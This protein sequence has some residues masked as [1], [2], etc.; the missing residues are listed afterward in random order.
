GEVRLGVGVELAAVNGPSSV[1]VA[2]DPVA[3]DRLVAEY[4]AE[5]VRVRR[6]PVDYASHTS[7]VEL[8][9][10]EL[11]E[12]L[13]GL[14]P[15]SAT[16]P[17][18]S[19]VDG[20]WVEGAE[21]D[22]GYWFRNLRQTVRFADATTALAAEGFRAFVEVSAHPV[23]AH[24]IQE[25]L[26]E[27][28]E[29]PSV[30]TGTLRRDD[31]GP[32]RLLLS[33]A[34]LY[35]RGI[36]VDW[37]TS[38]GEPVPRRVELPTYAFQRQRYWLE[39]SPGASDLAAVG[40]EEAG[41]PLL[42]A[43]ITLADTDRS[44]FS[45]RLTQREHPWLDD[46]RVGGPMLL[47]GTALLDMLCHIGERLRVP[48]VDELTISA[49]IVVPD[50]GGVDLQITVEHEAG[51]GTRVV[52]VY[53]RSGADEGWS[54]NATGLLTASSEPSPA[55]A[56]LTSWPPAGARPVD[57]D[58]FYDRLTVDYGPAFRAVEAAWVRDGRV[59]AALRLPESGAGTSDEIDGYG[60]HPALLDAALHPLSVSD[61]FADPD[62]PRLAFSWAGVRL[63]ATGARSLR[64]VLAPAGP[65][66]VSISAADDTG[67]PVL[68]VDALTVRPVDPARL[69]TSAPQ[70]GGSLFEVVWVPGPAAASET[71]QWAFH[72]GLGGSEPSV[73][74]VVVLRTPD[75]SPDRTVPE[76]V[77]AV[78]LN[79]L[80][81][82]QEWLADP[83]TQAS[84]L[85]V[86][87]RR[88]DLV[89]EPVRGLVRT[90]QSEHPGRFGLLEVERFD[91]ESVS[92]GLGGGLLD[93]PQVAVRGEQALV[94]RLTR[95]Q[96]A[97]LPERPRLAGGTVLVTG[98]TGGLGRLVTDHL[99]R[100]HE[101]A[102]LV[103][104]SRSG[105]PDE[106]L[107]ELSASGVRVSAVA[108]DVGDREALARIVAAVSDRLTAVV[109][110]AGVVDDGVIGELDAERWHTALRPKVDAA[111]HLHE[112]TE[113]L[114][115]TAFVLYSSASSTFGGSGQ[116]NYA[117]GNAFLDAL[118]VHRRAKGLAAVSLAWG[119]WAESAGMGGRLSDTDLAR[120]ARAG[121]RPLS[122]EQGLA[123]FDA[124]LESDS[125]ALVPI[126]LDLAAV[127]DSAEIPVLLSDLV[128]APTRRVIRR[129][130]AAGSDSASTLKRRLIALGADEQL[131]VLLDLVRS[132]AAAVLG[133]ATADAIEAQRAFKELGVDSLTA[134]ELR[135]RLT[136]ATGLRL[137]VTL[138]FNYPTAS[139]LAG[140]LR[141]EL[142]GEEALGQQQP[143]D[144]AVA[145]SS[146]H[147]P[148][149][150]A[151][152][153]IAIVAIGC[154][155]PGGLSSAEDLW[156]LV[157]AGGD[158]I[159]GL[160]SDRG[161]DLDGLYDPDP[162]SPGK[163]YVR[164]GGFLQDVGGF[165]AG[166]F[167]INPRE[168]LAMDPQQRLL[169]E[170][171]WE[172]LERAGI[173]PASLKG[174]PTGVFVGTHGQDYG[175]GETAG[176]ADEGYLV[177]GNAGSVLSGR[178]SYTLGL[179]G[180]ALTVDTACSSSLVA[181]H[182][183]VQALRNGECTLALAGGVS[184]MSTLEGVVGFSRQRGLATDGRSKAF[185][186]SA[187][188]FGMSEG[189]GI[190]LV[191]R[192]SDA[193]RLGHEVLAVVRG[194]AVNQ[195]GASNGLTAPN[196][197][198]QERVI[199]QALAGARLS[200]S[201]VDAVEA[202]GTG[203][204][205]GDP[206]EA[207]ALL[208][209][210]GKGRPAESPLWM[211]SVKSNIGHAQAAAGVAGVI[212]MVQAIRH[213]VLPRTLHV[214]E[215]SSKVDWSSGAVELLT[216]S[217]SWPEVDR[218]RRAGVSAF[219][220]SGTNAHVIVEQAP[221]V[222]EVAVVPEVSDPEPAVVPWVISGA[223]A[224]G[225]R[226]QAERLESFA[227]EHQD[228]P[229]PAIGHALTTTRGA[230]AHRA[231]VLAGDRGGALAGVSVVAG[232]GVGSG[233]VSGV[234]DVS[235][236]SV[237]VFPGQGSQWVGMGRDLLDSSPVFAGA[238]VEV[239]GVLGAVSG[240][241]VL[242]VVRGVEGAASLD[243]VDVV[244]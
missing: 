173:D 48:V 217:R 213:G 19:S 130:T 129:D 73:P 78:G 18:Y 57:M 138:V 16:I 167:G 185:A 111:W 62:S 114:D 82:L 41:H 236:R 17:M 1:V 134:V 60:I 170:V 67:A 151:D 71:P 164:G 95:A 116:G 195:D 165:D 168:A 40:L 146:S 171:S 72:T 216:E 56:D 198:S 105:V 229:D 135:N 99:V 64:V 182:L 65:D 90:A 26:D 224:K 221:V 203:T 128:P 242:D 219:G 13:A 36:P 35:V 160:P 163:T 77:H 197:P 107:A 29:A 177:T 124:A 33:V 21:L 110:V 4:E 184:V 22:G 101:V 187:D 89:Q 208:A 8:I 117:A 235:G 80:G 161:W 206:I 55:Q 233:V 191:E 225:L 5:G 84:R 180:P 70:L 15:R 34:E 148:G 2:G 231:V 68:D 59:Y 159:T 52:R 162:D 241:S 243:R 58:G 209:T 136:A 44:V 156:Q 51:P 121:T 181:L 143:H 102:E 37:S 109:H 92:A 202:H 6:V 232:G 47:P 215:P 218:P 133:H 91:E 20:R 240:W 172:V 96:S 118:A 10:A 45:G 214:D 11:A 93:E 104:V 179:E 14:K 194:S 226:G 196:G 94:A 212:K 220:V 193:R 157:E 63:H 27:K 238:L 131:D 166:F 152:E 199:R 211:G 125:P 38:F 144:P 174:T 3:L 192:L 53:T 120:M 183:A 88:D 132:S 25:T 244:Q 106:R 155:F 137:P 176:Q 103:L 178:V 46:H 98:A 115:L 139:E 126:R 122:A 30:V 145:S 188:G 119:L 189:V 24:S 31:G 200:A 83:R 237:F 76:Q 207:Q 150:P 140:H 39:P 9:E 97:T 100:S 112:L 79:V 222:S 234:A 66:T 49:P 204:P 147:A 223:S 210:Y 190:L 108:A 142:L 239:S 61:F 28:L 23:L 87:T 127:R 123:L 153:P 113:G 186:E 81:V 228:L 141:T 42:Q 75:G 149:A 54:E 169:L 32:D 50:G 175:T 205:L 227:R 43:A 230:F 201:E 74:P 7:Q 69:R 158:V 85:V 86:A 12:V 154:R